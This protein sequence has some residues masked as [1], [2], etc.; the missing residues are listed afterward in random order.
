[1]KE[2]GDWKDEISICENP[3][4]TSINKALDGSFSMYAQLVRM[5][6]GLTQIES[7]ERSVSR[8]KYV[9]PSSFDLNSENAY[10]EIAVK[11]TEVQILHLRQDGPNFVYYMLL[12]QKAKG[13]FHTFGKTSNHVGKA[14]SCGSAQWEIRSNVGVELA[15]LLS[16][17]PKC[18]TDKKCTE[19]PKDPPCPIKKEWP[20][21]SRVE[22]LEKLKAP[23]RDFTVEV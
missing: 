23:L 10:K 16:I 12:G 2:D 15:E 14:R 13:L 17:G 22:A 8:A 11:A 5:R 18:M 9:L 21:L 20:K 3:H 19:P 7:P 4:S 1:M 6:L